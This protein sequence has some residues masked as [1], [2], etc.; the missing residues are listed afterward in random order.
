MDIFRLVL[1][2]PI[3]P[4][5]GELMLARASSLFNQHLIM[6]GLPNVEA[7]P[8]PTMDCMKGG[9]VVSVLWDHH[10]KDVE[11]LHDLPTRLHPPGIFA[12]CLYESPSH[13]PHRHI[14]LPYRHHRK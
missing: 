5:L 12:Q 14:V 3:P 6:A 4:S 2:G 7:F 9:N 13:F 8:D 10:L 1:F 11:P